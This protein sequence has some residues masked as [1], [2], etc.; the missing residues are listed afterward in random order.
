MTGVSIIIC[1]FNSEKR[2]ANTLYHIAKQKITSF[3]NWE[4]IVVDNNSTD[5]TI[6]TA[7]NEWNKYTTTANFQVVTESVQGLAAARNRGVKESTYDYLLFCDDDNWLCENYVSIAYELLTNNPKIGI[8]GGQSEASTDSNTT[9]PKWFNAV[10]NSYAVGKQCNSSGD[11]TSRKFLWGA[12]MV[13]RKNLYSLVHKKNPSLLIGRKGEELSSGEDAELCARIILL[14][15]TLYYDE[16][17]FYHHFI[18]AERLTKTYF[19]NL[20]QGHKKSYDLIKYYWDYIDYINQP[21]NVKWEITKESIYRIL[22]SFLKTQN[23]NRKY[24]FLRLYLL[25]KNVDFKLAN[26]YEK[27]VNKYKY[28]TQYT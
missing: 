28:I 4:I 20:I 1:C 17:L 21:K 24:Y 16:K 7:Y 5:N 22:L 23:F 15:Y 10:S 6:T 25:W 3:I 8:I 2:L 9:L 13:I 26:S 11:A 18:S 14:G 27:I 19:K 12:G